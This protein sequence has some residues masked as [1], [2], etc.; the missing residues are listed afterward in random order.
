MELVAITLEL[1]RIVVTLE[2]VEVGTIVECH[3]AQSTF[4][5]L[6]YGL[7]QPQ[8]AYDGILWE[9]YFIIDGVGAQP[10]VGYTTGVRYQKSHVEELLHFKCY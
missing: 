10:D 3:Y 5:F 8:G 7:E 6:Q 4:A 9:Q 2:V 1:L